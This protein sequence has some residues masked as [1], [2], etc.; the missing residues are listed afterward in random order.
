MVVVAKVPFTP[1][2]CAVTK[3]EPFVAPFPNIFIVPVPLITDVAGAVSIADDVAFTPILNA[4]GVL[5]VRVVPAFKVT[6]VE[7]LLL[8]KTFPVIGPVFPAAT[9]AS[10]A[11]P[12][13]WAL[14]TPLLK[15]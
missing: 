2:A 1:L 14:A 3:V 6:P 15:V 12:I 11:S 7:T 10:K 13:A 5:I 4:P 9:V 8:I